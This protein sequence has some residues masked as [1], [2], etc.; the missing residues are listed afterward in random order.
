RLV[1][2]DHNGQMI[3]RTWNFEDNAGYWLNRYLLSHGI[4]KSTFIRD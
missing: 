2:R 1:I 3:W 4:P